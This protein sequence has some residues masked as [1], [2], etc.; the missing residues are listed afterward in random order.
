MLNKIFAALGICS[1]LLAGTGCK[2]A[3]DATKVEQP[4]FGEYYA[5]DPA[6]VESGGKF[7]VYATKDPWGGEDLAVF[8][9]EDFVTWEEKS[10]NW[11]TKSAC[12]SP[13][14]RG[15][16]V[17]APD[18]I[19]GKDG[20][21]YMYVSVG[22]EIWAGE[23]NHPLGPW[24][25]IKED[26]SPLVSSDAY[27]DAVHN[28][29]ANCFI[30]DDGRIYLYWGSG[31]DWV[32]GRCMA[33]ELADDMHT[34]LNDPKDITPPNFFEGAFMIKRNQKYYLMYSAGKAID[35]TYHIR[36]SIGKSPMGPWTEGKYSPVAETTP[37]SVVYGPGHHSV[38]NHKDQDYI[39]YHQIY[40][41]DEEYVLRQLYIDSLN[42]DADGNILPLSFD[43]ILPLE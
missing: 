11:P 25:N 27:G 9:T 24:N 19:K 26:N 32:N 10:L 15:S 36:Y 30:D 37:D 38:F 31:W 14:S 42:Y 18:I 16:N 12:T 35:Y 13:T 23:S 2:R 20:R 8:V 17:W 29:D 41:Q 3:S 7:Y 22:S 1:M 40:P 33:V 21:F 34:F 28:I 4:L 5:A 43:G 6:I 39:L